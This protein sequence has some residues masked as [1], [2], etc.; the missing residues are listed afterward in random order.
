MGMIT[1]APRESHRIHLEK[2]GILVTQSLSHSVTQSPSHSVT[3][4]LSQAVTLVLLFFCFVSDHMQSG[5]SN[6]VVL[7][8]A[9]ESLL[10]LAI[11]RQHD[12][13]WI[14]A[15]RGLWILES[16]IKCYGGLEDTNGTHC[17]GL[18]CFSLLKPNLLK[19]EFPSNSHH[20]NV[21]CCQFTYLQSVAQLL[22]DPPYSNST[23]GTHA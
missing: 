13:Y 2:Y 6:A 20:V 22:T 3:Q 4:T 7:I 14:D 18:N 8:L 17:N 10:Y 12:E 23:F 16:I 19:Q 11:R 1:R 21:L 5:S 15:I 9:H